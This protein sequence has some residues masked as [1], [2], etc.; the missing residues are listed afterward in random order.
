MIVDGKM[1]ASD[2]ETRVARALFSFKN[3]PTLAIV[4][5]G[6]DPVILSF[7]RIKKRMAERLK[8]PVV[9]RHFERSITGEELKRAIKELAN[10]AAINGI[11]IQLPLPKHIDTQAM[12]DAVPVEKDLDVLAS[13][14]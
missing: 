5:I 14:S 9:E 1:I 4:I 8:I 6:D 12:L 13:A 7:V 3:I 11:I 10:D 2:I